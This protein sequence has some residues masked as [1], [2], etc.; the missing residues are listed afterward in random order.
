M[1][2]FVAVEVGGG[3]GS[4]SA[5]VCIANRLEAADRSG[6]LLLNILRRLCGAAG[7]YG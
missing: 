4:P 6:V 7:V 2:A 3:P 5:A 1:W